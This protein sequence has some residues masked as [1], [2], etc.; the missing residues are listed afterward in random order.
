MPLDKKICSYFWIKENPNDMFNPPYRSII[1]ITTPSIA[2]ELVASNIPSRRRDMI[3]LVV[4][5]YILQFH[6]FQAP[7]YDVAYLFPMLFHNLRYPC[8]KRIE[9]L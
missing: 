1:C 8:V 9:F 2:Y 6:I 5:K 4:M 3:K 7:K